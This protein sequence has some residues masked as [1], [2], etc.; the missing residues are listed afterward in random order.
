MNL[1]LTDENSSNQ[2]TLRRSSCPAGVLAE[3]I[4]WMLA[5]RL[6]L[7]SRWAVGSTS[8][9]C[10]PLPAV[11]PA[12]AGFEGALLLFAAVFGALPVTYS[13]MCVG[14]VMVEPCHI[15]KQLMLDTRL[16]NQVSQ[17]IPV[18]QSCCEGCQ[19]CMQ[20]ICTSVNVNMGSML[21][22]CSCAVLRSLSQ[23]HACE[24][25]LHSSPAPLEGMLL[26]T[27]HTRQDATSWRSMKP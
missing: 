26:A 9:D 20:L 19:G 7:C 27:L 21:C 1:H 11:L 5:S 25:F 16:V 4:I 15:R 2:H 24:K 6:A 17:T 13:R 8:G 12:T 22:L 18:L 10:L 14:P 3:R 23:P